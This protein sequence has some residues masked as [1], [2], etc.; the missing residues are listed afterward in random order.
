MK[1]T[2]CNFRRGKHTQTPKH[3]IIEVKGVDSREKAAKLLGKKVVW[4][5]P[6]GKK[7]QGEIKSAHGNKGAL[8]AIF[9]H[10]LPGQSLGSQVDIEG[11]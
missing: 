9:E 10:G 1:G 4:T 6:S 7:L 2:V 8:R 5:S 3:M 11:K